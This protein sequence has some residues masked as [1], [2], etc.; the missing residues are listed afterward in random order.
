VFEDH[1]F[2]DTEEAR[3]FLSSDCPTNLCEGQA[4]LCLDAGITG[5]TANTSE[6]VT[7]VLISGNYS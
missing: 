5:P 6:L 4:N 1:D 2:G 3:E 7:Q